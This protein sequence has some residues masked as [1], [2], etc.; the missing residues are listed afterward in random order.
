MFF[1][2]FCVQIKWSIFSTH[3]RVYVLVY[4]KGAR[5]IQIIYHS[6]DMPMFCNWNQLNFIWS[7]GHFFLSRNWLKISTHTEWWS[8][9]NRLF[10]IMCLLHANR[11]T[12]GSERRDFASFF[13]TFWIDAKLITLSCSCENYFTPR[14]SDSHWHFETTEA[15]SSNL[16]YLFN[17]RAC[18]RID[19]IDWMYRGRR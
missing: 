10:V 19:W 13:H 15:A 3:V 9:K 14:R 8:W 17:A 16:T 4:I 18:Y 2:R 1:I 12:H 7:G 5:S 6:F 11:I